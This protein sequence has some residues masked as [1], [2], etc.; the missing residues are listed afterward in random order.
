MKLAKIFFVIFLSVLSYSFVFG[1][2]PKPTEQ[3]LYPRFSKIQ[4]FSYIGVYLIGNAE[5][6]GLSENELT[7]YIKLKFRNNFRGIQLLT[8]DQALKISGKGRGEQLGYIVV[9][10]F[11]VGDTDYPVAYHVQCR[12]GNLRYYFDNYP[13]ALMQHSIIWERPSLGFCKKIDVLKNIK[14]SI[15]FLIED[16]A[17]NFFKAR[18]EL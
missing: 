9:E 3:T 17:I 8:T 5:K 14:E 12:A 7:D 4:G 10:V 15:T 16:L 6:I 18:G 11:T 13:A 1:E 2:E